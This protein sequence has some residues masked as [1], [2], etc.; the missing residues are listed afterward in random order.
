MKESHATA[1]GTVDGKR[2]GVR[3]LPE[4]R[5]DPHA[6]PKGRGVDAF[7]VPKLGIDEHAGAE[8]RGT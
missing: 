8:G 1:I 7:H 3:L 4:A 5:L 6:R 2:G